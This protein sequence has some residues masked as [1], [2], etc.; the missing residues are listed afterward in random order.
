M[1]EYRYGGK[2]VETSNYEE[3]LESISE[4]DGFTYRKIL[5]VDLE[6]DRCTVL[7]SD[8]E[9]WQPG[10]GPISG[11]LARFALDG[12]I[13]P[14]D[15][16]RF[17]TFTR[18]DQLRR[19]STGSKEVLSLI[20]RRKVDDGFRWNLMEIIPDRHEGSNFVTLCIKDVDDLFR[21]GVE[22]E[23]L[24]EGSLEMFR[25][26]EDRA[27]IIS[28]LSSLFFSTYYVD[29][30][31]D[32]FR[33]VIQLG[34]VGDV[35]GN[36]VNYT[37]ALKLFATHFIH[38]DDRE[39]YLKIMGQQNLRENL[40]WWQPCVA[41]EYRKMPEKPGAGMDKEKWVRASVVL[42]RTGEDDLPM[43]AVYVA[44]DITGGRRG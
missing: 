7:K 36:E 31:Q 24:G 14:N 28:S 8:P 35:L 33:A 43:T 21:E 12:A 9:G 38:P 22:R 19:A 10:D 6:K 42:A 32:T 29:L 2:T 3:Y 11:Q 5:R 17:V 23:G 13:H 18:L 1:T 44:Q 16:E 20:Y 4:T 25:N 26:L 15:A 27:Y 39:E 40:R 41:Y 37:A 34:R 30:E